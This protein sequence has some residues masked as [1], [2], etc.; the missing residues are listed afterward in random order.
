MKMLSLFNLYLDFRYVCPPSPI[1]ETLQ[2]GDDL[3]NDPV[4]NIYVS[5]FCDHTIHVVYI[6]IYTYYHLP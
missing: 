2:P 4:A 6:Y 1:L 3:V 5:L